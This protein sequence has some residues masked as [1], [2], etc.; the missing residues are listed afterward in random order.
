MQYRQPRLLLS[1]PGAVETLVSTAFDGRYSGKMDVSMSKGKTFNGRQATFE[2]KDN[3]LSCDFPKMGKMPGKISINL[4]VKID[5]QG[6]ITAQPESVAGVMKMPMG[7]KF[8]LKLEALDGAK[9]D[10]GK[11]SFTLKVYGEMLGAKFPTTICF[12]GHQAQRVF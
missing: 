8:K 5:Q 4:F 7:F 6:R 3:H 2:I 12:K 1:L 11:I 10:D 9:I